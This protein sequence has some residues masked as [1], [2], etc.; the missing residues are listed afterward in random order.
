[1]TRIA[2]KG[3]NGI[4]PLIVENYQNRFECVHTTKWTSLENFEKDNMNFIWLPR[5]VKQTNNDWIRIKF[6]I[7]SHTF[8]GIMGSWSFY[9]LK[10]LAYKFQKKILEGNLKMKKMA[11]RRSMTSVTSIEF[12]QDIIQ[13]K[14]S[15][16]IA[17]RNLKRKTKI[18]TFW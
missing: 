7:D 1:M 13:N 5:K 8:H 17:A 11:L 9:I 3:Q 6:I 14:Q 10:S 18:K 2:T 12:N 15:R 16:G 4:K